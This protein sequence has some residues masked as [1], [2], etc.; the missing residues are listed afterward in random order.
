M[1][2][3]STNLL[4]ASLHRGLQNLLCIINISTE[5]TKCLCIQSFMPTGKTINR[6]PVSTCIGF[7]TCKV[8]CRSL[9]RGC[10]SSEL[11]ISWALL[12][13]PA[14]IFLMLVLTLMVSTCC[15]DF[16]SCSCQCPAQWWASVS[17]FKFPSWQ[18]SIPHPKLVIYRVTAISHF[19]LDFAECNALLARI[20][21]RF[22]IYKRYLK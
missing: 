4:F 3:Y 20:K 14:H 18:A 10:L 8:R 11:F 16:F 17:H 22:A 7:R 2:G 9:T 1:R 13:P 21:L 6:V 12:P 5:Y 19:V 15:Q